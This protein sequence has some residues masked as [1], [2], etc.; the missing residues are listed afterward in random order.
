[1]NGNEF[2]ISLLWLISIDIIIG[3]LIFMLY[4]YVDLKY[5]SNLEIEQL[6]TENKYLK[7]ENQKIKGTSTNFWSDKEWKI[8]YQL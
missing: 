5:F 2:F 6:K 1:M 8:V 7:E 4:K 3:F